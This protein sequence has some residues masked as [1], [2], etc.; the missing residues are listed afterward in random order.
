MPTILLAL[1]VK[2]LEQV[3][4]ERGLSACDGGLTKFVTTELYRLATDLQTFILFIHLLN[5]IWTYAFL[6]YLMS[7]E[8]LVLFVLTLALSLLGP[9]GAFPI[10]TVFGSLAI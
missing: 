6:F 3:G 4:S 10:M 7:F 2:G 5:L 8:P 1:L 9:V